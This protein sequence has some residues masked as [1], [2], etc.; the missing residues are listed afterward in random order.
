MAEEEIS[1]RHSRNEISKV[2]FRNYTGARRIAWPS[3]NEV[4]TAG[5]ASAREV[6]RSLGGN[7]ATKYLAS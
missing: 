1:F 3:D 2:Q 4:R 6:F 7:K 5:T